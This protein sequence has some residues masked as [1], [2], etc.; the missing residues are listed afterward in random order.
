L[1]LRC[2]LRG[3][4]LA[5]TDHSTHRFPWDFFALSF[6]FSWLVWLPAVL[7]NLGVVSFPWSAGAMGGT[8]SLAGLFGPMFSACV[9]TYR[10]GGGA[11]LL[12]YLGRLGNFHV[13]SVWWA[14]II[15]LPTGIQAVAH[16]LPLLSHEPL[17]ASFLSSPWMF[18]RI[19]LLVTLIG[20]GQEELGWRAYA[21]DRIQSR[22]SALVSSLILGSLWACWHIPL[23]FMQGT[24]QGSMAFAPFLL[25]CM[26]LSVILT[27]I[28]NNTGK[29]MVAAIMTHGMVNA[30]HALFPVIGAPG[31]GHGEYLY[32][33]L[34]NVV[35]AICI[36]VVWGPDTLT[37]RKTV[38]SMP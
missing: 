3:D 4:T 12:R 30:V 20:G 5:D 17:L 31:A 33:A 36:A 26:S 15:V 25:M 1:N 16:F 11:G 22:F 24:S 14:V 27:W 2:S 32:W 28:Y 34:T 29:N 9:L 18:F 21:L 37:G 35:V 19:L 6:G 8:L 13:R 38:S 23:W 10:D 7:A